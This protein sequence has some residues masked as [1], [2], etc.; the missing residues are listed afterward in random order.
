MD[1][2]CWDLLSGLLL[3]LPHI[4]SD[5]AQR[6]VYYHQGSWQRSILSGEPPVV[7]SWL[8]SQLKMDPVVL[9]IAKT[10]V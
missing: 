8:G 10:E 2:V 6:I 5:I 3:S 7:S 9:V 1:L 4:V